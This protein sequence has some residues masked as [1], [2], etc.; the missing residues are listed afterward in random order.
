MTRRSIFSYPTS[1]LPIS[2]GYGERTCA[3]LALGN[4]TGQI[5]HRDF[6]ARNVLVC[7]DGTVKVI[8]FGSSCCDQPAFL[9][10]AEMKDFEAKV[11]FPFLFFFPSRIVAIK[12][13]HVQI[14]SVLV[15]IQVGF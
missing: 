3:C 11:T 5:C 7:A 12:G 10:W 8:D 1:N 14:S 2:R 6:E 9:I 13:F 15:H 4:G